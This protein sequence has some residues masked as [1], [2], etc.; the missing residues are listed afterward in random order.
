MTLS[1]PKVSCRWDLLMLSD[2]NLYG[3]LGMQEVGGCCCFSFESVGLSKDE[4]E[5]AA[6][7]I[8]E[9]VITFS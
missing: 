9:V 1:Y 8:Q 6:L 7:L 2:G 3:E 5:E 4:A